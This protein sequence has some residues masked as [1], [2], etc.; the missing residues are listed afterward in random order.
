VP[1]TLQ[2][3]L[4]AFIRGGSGNFT[5]LALEVFAFQYAHNPF[6]RA[7]CDHQQAA[8]TRWEDIP[9]VPTSAFKEF[10]IACFPVSEAL[11]EF[12]TSGTTSEKAGKH[13]FKT[14]E[15]YDAAS[16]PNFI[17]HLSPDAADLPV[18]A[19]T[20]SPVEAP[21]S[22]LAHMLGIVAGNDCEF[23]VERDVLLLE[24]L[25]QRL[26]EIQWDNQP[27]MLLGTAFAF[28]HLFDHLATTHFELPEGS[29]AMETGGFKGRSRAVSKPEL[30][31]SFTSQLGIPPQRI[32]NEYGMTELSTQFYDETMRIDRQ[33]DRK[34]VSPWARVLIIDPATGQVAP[35]GERGLIRV[36]DLANLWSAICIQTEDLGIAHADG[37][38]EVL[39]RVDGAEVRGCS[40]NAEALR[41]A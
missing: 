17:A 9:A 31:K 20:P 24:R 41:K 4:L 29:R 11:A 21:H 10:S 3:K 13:Y 2:Q 22:S 26:C 12:H 25:T 16:R 38:F 8:V 5:E 14:R 39:G 37:T 27:V 30:Y 40:L 34:T 23:F 15:L 7:F 33:S 6:Y 32:V 35:A 28:V 18:L 1:V 36:L 19:L